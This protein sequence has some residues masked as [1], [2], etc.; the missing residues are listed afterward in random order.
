MKNYKSIKCLPY[1]LG[2]G[3]LIIAVASGCKKD[4]LDRDP[5]G[6]YTLDNYP[7][8]Q[9]S[10]P[11]DAVVFNAYSSMRAYGMVAFPAIGVNSIRSDD[12]DKGSTAADGATQKQMDEFPV[13]PSNGLVN[14]YWQDHFI[15]VTTANKA[16]QL[17]NNDSVASNAQFR[18]Q[19]L[20]EAR[21]IR[22]HAYFDLVR[23][24][25]A[26]P[27]LDTAT[28]V[29]KNLPRTSASEIYSFIEADLMFAANNLP[30]TYPSAFTGRL[31]TNAAKGL[32]AKVYLTRGNWSMAMA[33]AGQV[34]NSGLY[35]LNTKYE[36]IFKESGENSSESIFEIQA[37]ASAVEKS[38]YGTEYAMHQGV[39]GTGLFNFGWGF[40][41]P[42]MNLFNAYE[43]N[44]PRRERTFLRQTETTYYG[45]TI[46][47]INGVPFAFNE[48]VYHSPDFRNKIQSQGGSWMNVRILRYAD[49][50][51][52][53]AE[54]ANEVGGAAN[55]TD[56][57]NKL[58]SI[59]ARARVGAPAGTLPDVTTADQAT[60][61]DAI[62][63]E[64]RFELA[65]EHDRFWDLIRWGTAA[66][67]LSSAGRPGY[68]PNRDN[69]LPIPQAQID[70]SGGVLTQNPNY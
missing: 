41:V 27:K 35:N 10:G 44:D 26:V 5:Q 24:F 31:T 9:G 33:M 30:A 56:A 48:K 28:N 3:F 12:A 42:N 55:I 67:A 53:Y 70:V 57:R 14:S 64:R 18:P 23:G 54:A 6:L 36:D 11:Y 7:F 8:P 1:L 4:F 49:V 13:L 61:R 37:T 68:V 40:N 38:A 66:T 19:A 46:P 16:I 15:T 29:P 51:L 20:A 25:G 62:R 2:I 22:A 69:L 32:L 52:M 65:M 58:N 34:I 60:L 45:E 50:V 21:F 43:A 39:R 59:R 63:S 47:T 17:I